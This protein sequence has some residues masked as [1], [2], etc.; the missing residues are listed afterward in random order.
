MDNSGSTRCPD[1][2]KAETVW[3][4]CRG[5]YCSEC[6][7]WAHALVG[8]MSKGVLAFHLGGNDVMDLYPWCCIS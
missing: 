5:D 2:L 1:G 8:E 6:L 4:L 7:C 3:D